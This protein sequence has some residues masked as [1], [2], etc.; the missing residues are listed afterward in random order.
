MVKPKKRSI[1][2]LTTRTSARALVE[3]EG[4]EQKRKA[5]YIE[6]R[7]NQLYSENVGS[8]SKSNLNEQPVPGTDISGTYVSEIRGGAY[9]NFTDRKLLITFKQNGTD[10][11]GTDVNQIKL[12]TGTRKG[13]SIKYEYYGGKGGLVTGVW[14]INSDGT[15]LE[16]TW[17]R[18]GDGGIWNLTKI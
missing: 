7:G 10:I 4:D 8:I 3:A 2:N 18:H 11:I 17:S 6:L 13:E 1:Q 16:G 12:I 15:R 9:M 5:K 14:K